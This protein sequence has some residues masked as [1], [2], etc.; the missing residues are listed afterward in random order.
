M[1]SRIMTTRFY[2]PNMQNIVCMLSVNRGMASVNPPSKQKN[3][4]LISAVTSPL[5]YD[6]NFPLPGHVGVDLN[7]LV[8]CNKAVEKVKYQTLSS[9]LL[10]LNNEAQRK[11]DLLTQFA[12]KREETQESCLTDVLVNCPDKV[13]CKIQTCPQ[14]LSKDFKK[15]FSS[16]ENNHDLTVITITQHTVND[17]AAWSEE[18]DKER[19]TLICMFIENAKMICEKIMASGYWADFIDPFSGRAF[20]SEYTND[21]LF[22]TDDRFN[23]LGFNVEDLGCCKVLFH[24]KWKSNVFVGV[25]FTDAPAQCHMFNN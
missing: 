13:E 17:M 4:A 5:S 8:S 11:H 16:Q 20:Y 6:P 24:N 12:S 1:A 25:I 15:L 22:E 2:A 3:D 9:V 7:S 14:N 21:T 23:Q 18:V 19:E 10:N